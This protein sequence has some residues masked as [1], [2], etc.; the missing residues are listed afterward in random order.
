MLCTNVGFPGDTNGKEHTCQC[1]RQKRHRLHP[2][3]RKRRAWQP[4]PAFLPRESHGQR[5]LA[6]Y[7]PRGHKKPDMT[8]VTWHAGTRAYRSLLNKTSQVLF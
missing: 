7:S 5:N 8:E 1:R 3:G 4:T 2:W 6:G